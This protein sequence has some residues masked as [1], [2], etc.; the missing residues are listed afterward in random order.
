MKKFDLIGGFIWLALGVLVLKDSADLGFGTLRQP[1]AGLFPLL[2]GSLLAIFGVLL[3]VEAAV[4]RR[5]RAA[6]DAPVWDRDIRFAVLGLVLVSLVLYVV[7]LDALGF[8]PATFLF[9]L[10]MFKVVEPQTWTTA[11]LS[12]VAAVCASYMVFQ[13]W[14][15]SQLP[16]GQLVSWL[17]GLF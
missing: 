5:A 10:I 8:L 14:L 2:S 3:L 1:G 15:G 4:K 16:E 12:S 7:F 11:L 13:W 9:L 17:A 6:E